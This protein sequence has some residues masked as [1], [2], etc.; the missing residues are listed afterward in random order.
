MRRYSP[1]LHP[2]ST[3]VYL[4]FEVQNLDGPV[5]SATLRLYV[6]DT[7]SDGLASMVWLIQ[8]GVSRP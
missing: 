8:H 6:M 3:I 4:R 5:A 7:N 1:H 2:Y